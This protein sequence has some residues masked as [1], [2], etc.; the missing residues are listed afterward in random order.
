MPF[1]VGDS[2]RWPTPA[3]T[4]SG[5]LAFR[6]RRPWSVVTGNRPP[7]RPISFRGVH[8]TH[9]PSA[10]KGLTALSGVTETRGRRVRLSHT[11]HEPDGSRQGGSGGHHIIDQGNTRRQRTRQGQTGRLPLATRTGVMRPPDTRPQ[12]TRD[13]DARDATQRL[14]EGD[15]RINAVASPPHTSARH[16]HERH[17]QIAAGK[18]DRSEP[19]RHRHH[20]RSEPLVLGAVDESSR[21]TLVQ[22]RAP[23]DHTGND[24]VRSRLEGLATSRAHAGAA[25]ETSARRTHHRTVCGACDTVEAR[26]RCLG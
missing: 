3:V 14:G 26:T 10:V 25:M 11:R 24:A 17:R 20:R 13:R 22:P 7:N 15:R 23:H 18:D 19:F 9:A 8:H 6:V 16:R 21:S 2:D 5:R 1:L 4:A 12:R